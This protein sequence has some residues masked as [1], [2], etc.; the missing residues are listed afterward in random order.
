MSIV[1]DKSASKISAEAF[2]LLGCFV[3]GLDD[4]VYQMAECLART[5]QGKTNP[6]DLVEIAR[7]DVVSAG[8]HVLTLLREQL[9][10][11]PCSPNAKELEAILNQ[12]EHC[13]GN[14]RMG[15]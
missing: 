6:N 8:E 4:V 5:R 1:E 15:C 14:R 3:A 9:K 7:E 11:A 13:F 12:I 2:D 10:S